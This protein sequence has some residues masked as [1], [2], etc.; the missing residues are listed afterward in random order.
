MQQAM[1]CMKLPVVG[2]V[3][4]SLRKLEWALAVA[5]SPRR[6]CAIS[7]ASFHTVLQLCLLRPIDSREGLQL[8]TVFLVYQ[9]P[10]HSS[11]L[12]LA[13][14]QATDKVSTDPK[15]SFRRLRT[16]S[17]ESNMVGARRTSNTCSNKWDE[18]IETV[19]AKRCGACKRHCSE[20]CFTSK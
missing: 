6:R 13:C 5:L 12:R 15:P 7:R 3:I 4:S 18:N 17:N 14:I 11:W 20:E 9:L 16:H 19:K 8:S 10:L 1:L 2:M